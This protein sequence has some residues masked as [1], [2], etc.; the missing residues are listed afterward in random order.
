M[1]KLMWLSALLCLTMMACSPKYGGKADFSDPDRV[2]PTEDV[3][4]AGP[5]LSSYYDFSDILIPREMKLDPDSSLLF[6]TTNLKAGRLRFKGWV[7][8]VSLFDF[9]M[10]NMPRDNWRLRSYFKYGVYLLVFEKPDKD[11]IVS[12]QKGTINS[13]LEVWVTPRVVHDRPE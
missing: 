11:C 2:T 4:A 12:I 1:K 9:F 3:D 8:P 10:E 5:A 7:D 6:E 13:W